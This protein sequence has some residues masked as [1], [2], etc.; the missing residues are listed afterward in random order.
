[1]A[2]SVLSLSAQAAELSSSGA[3][4]VSEKWNFNASVG[5]TYRDEYARFLKGK[6]NSAHTY[7]Q[8]TTLSETSAK[9]EGKLFADYWHARALF[10]ANLTG[11]AFKGFEKLV[12]VAPSRD[13]L[14]VQVAGWECLNRIHEAHPA[15]SFSDEL[16]SALPSFF[17]TRL[18]DANKQTLWEAA[19]NVLNTQVAENRSPDD[20]STTLGLMSGSGAYQAFATAVVA[21]HQN[22]H[23]QTIAALEPAFKAAIPA[24]LKREQDRARLLLAR[25]YYSLGQ[26]DQAATQYDKVDRKSNEAAEMLSEM[27]W[28]YLQSERYS[29]AVGTATHLQVGGLRNTYAPEANLVLAM[30]LNEL[31]QYQDSLRATQL[32]EQTYRPSYEW[33]KAWSTSKKPLYNEAIQYLQNKSDTTIPARVAGEWIRSSV[34]LANQDEI[35][36]LFTEDKATQALAAQGAQEEANLAQELKKLAGHARLGIREEGGSLKVYADSAEAAEQA[37]VKLKEGVNQYNRMHSASME[38]QYMAGQEEKEAKSLQ[39]K[40]VQEINADLSRRNMQMLAQLTNVAENRKLIDIEIFNGASH[41]MI[42]RNAHPDFEEKAKLMMTEVKKPIPGHVWDWGKIRPNQGKVE[43][44][45]D[46]LGSFKAHLTDNCANKE[47]YLAL[48]QK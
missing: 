19:F 2:G 5:E 48:Q 14:G 17:M 31:C 42:W 24:P 11:L 43:I 15:M 20:I 41:D 29:E 25:A 36:R 44:W 47:K 18:T 9:A 32:L 3:C 26:Y 13:T 22:A 12:S 10:E 34:F 1:M 28:S 46:E 37:P 39:S 33:L 6:A 40:L 16:S 38:W 30:S 23:A 45:E 7:V 4:S 27:S 35:H 21:S 8:A